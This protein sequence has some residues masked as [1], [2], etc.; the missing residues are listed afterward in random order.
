M[1]VRERNRSALF[2][3]RARISSQA[4][5]APSWWES[6]LA[7]ISSWALL[8]RSPEECFF[9]WDSIPCFLRRFRSI[10][11]FSQ[12]S[13]FYL[14]FLLWRLELFLWGFLLV[15][16][17]PSYLRFLC[18]TIP[19][20]C[21]SFRRGLLSRNFSCLSV[22]SQVFSARYRPYLPSLQWCFWPLPSWVLLLSFLLLLS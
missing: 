4:S 14:P 3:H 5:L 11:L 1:R 21:L 13:L 8:P 9:P 2:S 20:F 12:L 18:S 16:F 17:R 7:V 6:K 15:C 22:R 19:I 10:R